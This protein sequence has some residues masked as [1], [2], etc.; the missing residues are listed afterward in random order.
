[1]RKLLT[2]FFF[3]CLVITAANAESKLPVHEVIPSA[4]SDLAVASLLLAIEK[5]GDNNVIVVGQHGHILLSSNGSDWQ[6]ADVPVQ[7]TLTNVYFL[8]DK[9]GWAVGHDATILHSQDGGLHWKIQQ[10][11]PELEKPLFD[12]YFKNA[13]QGI[14]VGAYGQVYRTND[15]GTHWI[16]EFHQELLI[17][18]DIDYLNELKAEDEAAYLD[19]I[20]FILPHFNR[21]VDDGKSLFL[22]GEAGFLAKSDDFSV[23]WQAFDNFYHGSFF[24][25]QR[26]SSDNLLIA[27]LRGHVF[28]KQSDSTWQQVSTSTTALLNDIILS[29]D[30]RIFI[31]G[32]NGMLLI[33]Q[34]DGQSFTQSVQVDG[35][36]LIAGVWFNNQ[37]L[38]VSDVG[39]KSL[40]PQIIK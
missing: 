40:T 24:A 22:L 7:T 33:S 17:A 4:K 8:N 2:S 38:V 35:K 36:A 16:S 9:L 14:A 30:G 29:D 18:D 5:V 11:L 32:N 39:V 19:E 37:L 6:Q 3:C 21:I 10:N 23:T 31:L 26:T 15:G 1:M 27:G 12:I 28:Y 20:N 13:S 34:D 25:L